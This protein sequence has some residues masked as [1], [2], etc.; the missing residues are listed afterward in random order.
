MLDALVTTAAG[1]VSA[2]VGVLV[3]GMVTRRAQDRQWLRDQQLVAY[4]ELFSHYAK[5]TME[6]RRAHGDRRGWDYDW[7]EW[8]A[9]LMRVSLIAPA[10]VATEIDDFGRAINAFLDQVARGRDPSNDPL[11]PEDFEQARQAPAEAQV[12]LVNAIRRSLSGDQKVLPFG[13]GG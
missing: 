9:A 1:A 12:K 8:N 11:S 5:F 6:L 13:I 3:G 2:T 4:Q 10:E 7:G